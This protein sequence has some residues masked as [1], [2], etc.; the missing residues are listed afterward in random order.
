MVV[1]GCVR[2]IKTLVEV[3]GAMWLEILGNTGLTF[4]R[5]LG[6]LILSSL[7]A[8][9]AGIWIGLNQRRI[10]IAQPIIQ[11]MAS[12]PAPMLYPLAL[13]VLFKLGMNLNWG[14]MF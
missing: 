1:A 6:A 12:F 3:P 5:V 14:S 4:L 7:W 13:A 2:L 8:V 10:R 11:V 9:P